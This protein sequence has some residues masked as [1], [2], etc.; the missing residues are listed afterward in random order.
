MHLSRTTTQLLADLKDPANSLAW[1]AFDSRYRPIVVG[2]LRKLGCNEA[3]AQDVAQDTMAR[4]CKL[5]ADGK[6]E[7]DKGRLRSWIVGIARYRM[8]SHARGD[9]KQIAL[10][11][12]SIVGKLPDDDALEEVFEV[13]HRAAMLREAMNRLRASGVGEKTVRV[14]ELLSRDG[15]KPGAIAESLAMKPEEVY[16]AKSRGL[17]KL[18]DVLAEVR[19]EY[20]PGSEP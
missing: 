20:E 14:L 11:A 4:F 5:Y 9:A 17:A 18:R 16:V 19:H 6:Y 13:E 15:L 8:M 3:D 2:F 7:R 1:E 12:G 10:P